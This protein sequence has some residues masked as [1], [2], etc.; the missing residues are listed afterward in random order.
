MPLRLQWVGGGFALARNQRN[1]PSL[2]CLAS[3]AAR[4]RAL[5]PML[6]AEA[7]AGRRRSAASAERREPE[8]QAGTRAAA[9]EAP[10][11]DRGPS[12]ASAALRQ[13]ARVPAARRRELAALPVRVARREAVRVPEVRPA[14]AERAERAESGGTGGGG[15]TGV[16][17]PPSGCRAAGTG[18]GGAGAGRAAA[19]NC[20]PSP[21]VIP[22]ASRLGDVDGDGRLDLIHPS[23]TD[24][25]V[26]RGCGDGTFETTPVVSAGVLSVQDFLPTLPPILTSVGAVADFNGDGR[27]DLMLMHLQ[28][29]SE[30]RRHSAVGP[31]DR[32]ARR[33]VR[34]I[35]WTRRVRASAH[36]ER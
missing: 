20:S 2:S 9:K 35:G 17:P 13:A 23:G 32:T 31:G 11:G 6:R 28:N 33:D 18:G 21:A 8:A 26:W 16:R 27:A 4:R 5:L 24:V 7:R 15:G 14:A 34:T 25:S 19:D 22:P 36:G 12:A 1:S 30:V 10:R 29:E 3:A